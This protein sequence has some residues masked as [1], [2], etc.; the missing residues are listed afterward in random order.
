MFLDIA[1]FFGGL[2]INTNCRAWRADYEH[3]NFELQTLQHR[4]LFQ[5]IKG[6]I[7]YIH[8]QSRDMGQ[9]IAMELP[10]MNRF[11]WKPNQLNY[12]IQKNEVVILLF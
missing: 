12:F 8:Y 7:L 11:V 9:N 6:G 2:K 10:I 1:C 5:Q 3:P 4:Y